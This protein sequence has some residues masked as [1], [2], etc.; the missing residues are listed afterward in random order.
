M[1]RVLLSNVIR[2]VAESIVEKFVLSG[3]IDR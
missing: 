3:S 1:G 2:K